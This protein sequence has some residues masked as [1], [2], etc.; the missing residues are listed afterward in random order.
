MISKFLFFK[1]K[2]TRGLTNND[3]DRK[4]DVSGIDINCGCPKKFSIQGG[5]GA[6]LLTEPEK[7]KKVSK[8]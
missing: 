8:H 1:K 7:L 2:K 4:D 3:L 5:M 6:A